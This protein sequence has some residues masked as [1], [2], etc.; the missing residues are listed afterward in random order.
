MSTLSTRGRVL[1][2]GSSALV[3]LAAAVL[4]ALTRSAPEVA[5]DPAVT[6]TTPG[7]VVRDTTTG[8]LAVV[9]PDGS[10]GQTA[11]GCSRVHAAGGRAVCLRPDPAS[12]ATFVLDVLGADLAVQ[13]TLPVN[14]VPTRARISADGRVVA[15]TVFVSGDSYTSSGFSTRSGILDLE[16]GVLTTSLEDFSLTDDEGRARKPPVD[17]NF[18]GVSFAD[19]D[20]TFY[21]TMA[22]GSHFYLVQ[23]DFAGETVTVLADGVECPSLSPDG[24]RLVYKHRLPDL[25]WRLEVYDLGSGRRTPLA[26][27]ADVDDQG[28]WLDDATIAYGRLDPATGAVGVWTVPADGSGAPA[29]LAADAESPSGRVGG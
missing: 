22:T 13:R 25:T 8:R 3:L 5:V 1:V 14:G 27:T 21:A 26:E 15:W 28:S 20:N 24:T 17:A 12:P 6:L 9:R 18:W 16:T 7:V 2:A 4:W 19:D 10:R 23:G 29:L 11:A